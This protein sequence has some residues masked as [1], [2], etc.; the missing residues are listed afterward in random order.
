LYS[1]R[2]SDSKEVYVADDADVQQLIEKVHGELQS[3]RE[4]LRDR[5]SDE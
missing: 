1:Q 2:R 4:L 5:L 3:I